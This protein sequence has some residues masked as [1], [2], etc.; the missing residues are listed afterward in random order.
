MG[1]RAHADREVGVAEVL[2]AHP[3]ALAAAAAAAPGAAA[4]ADGP[5]GREG[6]VFSLSPAR[7]PPRPPPRDFPPRELNDMPRCEGQPISFS[8]W[9]RGSPRKTY[10]GSRGQTGP[11][12]TPSFDRCLSCLHSRIAA[13][14]FSSQVLRG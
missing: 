14:T 11:R 13:V 1:V 4:A 2:E 3:E 6:W 10:L 12:G 9:C 7:R 5:G 8:W